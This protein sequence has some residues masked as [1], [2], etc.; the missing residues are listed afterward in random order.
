MKL[1][2]IVYKVLLITVLIRHVLILIGRYIYLLIES[3]LT[4]ETLLKNQSQRLNLFARR[5]L[6][7]IKERLGIVLKP[8]RI[9][10]IFI[11]R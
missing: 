8:L 11:Q 7:M 6:V 4:L 10:V 2:L 1:K 9:K 3:S 5:S